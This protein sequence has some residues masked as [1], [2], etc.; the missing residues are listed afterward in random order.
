VKELST[1]VNI[2]RRRIQ[3]IIRLNYLSHKIVE[4]IVNGR[5]TSSLRLGNLKEIPLLW[6][7]QLEKFYG[8]AS[9]IPHM[10]CNGS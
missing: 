3:Q 7:E 5:Q 9:S 2:S 10:Y 4:G 6:S 1:I 8:L